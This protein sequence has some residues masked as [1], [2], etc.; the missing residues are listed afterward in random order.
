M[1]KFK[2]DLTGFEA[3]QKRV[4]DGIEVAQNLDMEEIKE[5]IREEMESKFETG[6][7]GEWDPI[8]ETTFRLRPHRI[9]GA[10][11][12]GGLKGGL[13]GSMKLRKVARK[14]E[15]EVLFDHPGAA[16]NN[17]GAPNNKMFGRYPAPI[18]ARTFMDISDDTIREINR[19]ITR[20]IF[21]ALFA[22]GTG[23]K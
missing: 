22:R 3:Y 11:P 2:I 8:T 13:F 5:V 17:F 14:N 23:K 7:E 20:Q 4:E 9:K 19:L 16:P 15:V 18:P 12:L 21:D 10:P 1:A 6:R